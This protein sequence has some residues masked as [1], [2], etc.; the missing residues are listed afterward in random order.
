MRFHIKTDL[1]ESSPRSYYIK[2][3][4]CVIT[5]YEKLIRYSNMGSIYRLYCKESDKSYIGQ[6]NNEDPT[7]RIRDHFM[8]AE[9]E[10]SDTVLYRAIRKYGRD[11]FEASRL[12]ICK[13]QEDLDYMEDYYITEYKSMMDEN[14]YN[15]KR[16]GM[17]RCIGYKHSEE[18]KTKLSEI[19]KGNIISEEQ[20][21]KISETSKGHKK[22][23]S[24][25]AL[26][27]MTERN[28]ENGSKAVMNNE[29]KKKISET[30]T[31]VKK[32]Y[33]KFNSKVINSNINK[34]KDFIEKVILDISY[35]ETAYTIE[36]YRRFDI[37]DI[38]FIRLFPKLYGSR[39]YEKL[40]G[41]SESVIRSIIK[42]SSYK[43]IIIPEKYYEEARHYDY[44]FKLKD[45]LEKVEVSNEEKENWVQPEYEADSIN[46]PKKKDK[47]YYKNKLSE[48]YDIT[49]DIY[50]VQS[51][52]D[53]IKIIN[54]DKK[55]SRDYSR[56]LSIDN[57]IF[58]RLFPTLFSA[59]SYGK[60]L[61]CSATVIRD[62]IKNNTYKD[63]VIPQE[64]YEK[65]SKFEFKK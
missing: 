25:E 5:I 26:E 44:L 29:I 12:C 14:G 55:S 41:C 21:I 45:E 8:E 23:W 24:E 50:Q 20:K 16:G 62:V 32:T 17:K 15:M 38:V 42:Y 6:H 18:V 57:I 63:I 48:D 43:D 36:K 22:K 9:C 59:I 65:A 30:L 7:K 10:R 53:K 3:I 56:K 40:Y 1:L 39:G 13:T 4:I 2:V 35:N 11:A 33:D 37:K 47:Q 46:I 64:Y 54:E 27:T 58:I 31:G 51:I 34:I 61:G 19:K 52:I 49:N 28:R 60:L